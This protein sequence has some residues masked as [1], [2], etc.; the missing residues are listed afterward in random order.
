MEGDFS[1][2]GYTPQQ[3]HDLEWGYYMVSFVP[4]AWDAIARNDIDQNT[5][6]MCFLHPDKYVEY[7]INEVVFS[8]NEFTVGFVMQTMETIAKRGWQKYKQDREL[9]FMRPD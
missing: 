7:T 2:L 1:N 9:N 4:G 3:K 8:L 6:F 5:N